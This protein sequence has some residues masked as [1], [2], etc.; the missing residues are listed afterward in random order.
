MDLEG[1]KQLYFIHHS[2]YLF[3]G[4][5][6]WMLFDYYTESAKITEYLKQDPDIPL[7]IFSTH[8]HGDHY[9][10]NVFS[11]FREHPGGVHFIF[12]EELRDKVPTSYA[13]KVLFLNTGEA[14]ST[15]HFTVKAYGSTD[16]GGSFLITLKD[17]YTLFHAGD[18]NNWHWNQE[19]SP[20]YIRQYEEQWAQELSRIVADAPLVDLL[21]FPTDLR[22]GPDYL[23]GL[24]Q[25]I[26]KIPTK[27][28]AP[29]HLN[30]TLKET[31]DLYQLGVHILPESLEQ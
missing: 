6:C 17:H 22:L 8:S 13:D 19:A 30:G 21:M 28:L 25:F 10:P 29:M 2:T 31:S 15:E 4:D 5:E 27:A 23:K 26:A 3:R 12:H 11:Q 14:S 7:Y 24:K 9:N 1:L 20:E 18:L 16:L